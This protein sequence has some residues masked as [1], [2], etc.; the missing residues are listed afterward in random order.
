MER[1]FPIL[2]LAC[3]VSCRH[4]L[5]AGFL[6]SRDEAPGTILQGQDVLAVPE[7]EVSL[8][9]RIDRT[10]LDGVRYPVSDK[11]IHYSLEG[12]RL[13]EAR[14]SQSGAAVLRYRVGGP[15]DYPIRLSL[16][17]RERAGRGTSEILL[18]V[19][20]A[21]TELMVVDIEKTL[22]ALS[23]LRFPFTPNQDIPAM[24]GSVET[25]NT[26]ALRRSLVYLSSGDP[27]SA[28]KVRGWLKLRGYPSAPV[29]YWSLPQEDQEASKRKTLLMK[30]FISQ[31]P[32]LLAG[33]G[34]RRADAVA[35]QE[36]RMAS[37]LITTEAELNLPTG[38]HVYASWRELGTLFGAAAGHAPASTDTARPGLPGPN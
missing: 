3:A 34:N 18:R 12:K 21:E 11:T 2:A 5:E 9:A 13:G 31:F 35:C 30:N 14:T 29:L 16:S 27:S 22:H 26:L 10:G 32:N 37:F 15:G 19:A 25:L 4:S 1:I 20:K 6:F 17:R 36:N 24:E 33:I 8:V 38:T 7:A 23:A 28:W